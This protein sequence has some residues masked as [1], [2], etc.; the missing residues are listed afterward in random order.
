MTVILISFGIAACIGLTMILKVFQNKKPLKAVAISHGI[1]AGTSLVLLI[2][3]SLK[4]KET[5]V[6]SIILFVLAALAGFFM[7]YKDFFS[8]NKEL[9][10]SSV[11]KPV[12]IIHAFAAVAAFLLL[13]I[14][15]IG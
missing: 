11:P 13:L 7:F 2:L 3:E 5:S 6:I 15:Y 10:E 8:T 4:G 1:F 9:L 14:A 12:A